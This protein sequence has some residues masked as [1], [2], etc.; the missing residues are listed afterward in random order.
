M[1]KIIKNN[2]AS[3]KNTRSAALWLIFLIA[4]ISRLDLLLELYRKKGILNYENDTVSGE[5]YIIDKWLPNWLTRN[6][7]KN[8]IIF[9]VGANIGNYASKL[10][11]SLPNSSI[12]A[13]EPNPE[14][15]KKMIV[16]M[17]G[18]N[19]IKVNQS[20]VG[21]ETGQI[22]LHGAVNTE[23]SEHCTIYKNVLINQHSY[24]DISECI[25]PITTVTRYCEDNGLNEIHLL[26]IDTEGHEFDVLLGAKEMIQEG[27]IHLIQFEFNE[28]NV[29]SRRFLKDFVDLL[30]N[31]NLHRVH[32]D[33]LIPL[34]YSSWEEI[35]LF[36]NFLAILK[37]R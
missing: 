10:A 26:K 33:R 21:A 20:A 32:T 31:Y 34:E 12:H 8:P 2:L 27:A 3:S 7:I 24:I 25:V 22:T 13:F 36:Q 16:R 28:M 11:S 23:A 1:L 9:D 14:T 15:Y 18:N 30:H 17:A 4:R 19:Q 6:G 29:V 5:G 35:F 37:G